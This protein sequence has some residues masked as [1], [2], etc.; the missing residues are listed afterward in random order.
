MRSIVFSP[1]SI[2]ITKNNGKYVQLSEGHTIHKFDFTTKVENIT[3]VKNVSLNATKANIRVYPNPTIDTIYI[4]GISER[5]NVA[6]YDMQGRLVM[7]QHGV[8]QL[9]VG[10]YP[11][12]IYIISIEGEQY[13]LVKNSHYIAN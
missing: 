12:G 4:E 3:D 11:S 9:N 10:S 13:K 5:D 7:S 6:V 1:Q 2:V 8:T